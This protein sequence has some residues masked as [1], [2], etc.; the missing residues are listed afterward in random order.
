[1]TAIKHIAEPGLVWVRKD[2]SDWEL[3]DTLYLSPKDDI[4]NY[5]QVTP[6]PIETEGEE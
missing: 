3:G 2:N 6:K 1:M 4:N 5:E